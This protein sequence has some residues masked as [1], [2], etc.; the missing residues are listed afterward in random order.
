[1]SK[2]LIVDDE[3]SICWGVARVCEKLGHPTRSASSAEAGLREAASW[4]PD[5]IVLDVRLPGVDGIT[6]IES[7]RALLG[8]VP[9]VIVTAFGDMA[10]AV[11]AVQSDAFDYLLKPFGVQDIQAIIERALKRAP[12]S[13]EPPP[14]AGSDLIGASTV[15]Q[16]LYKRVALAAASDASVLLQGESGSGKELVARAIH[17]HS[18]RSK[19]RFVAVNVAAL[20]PSLAESELFGHVDG[21]FT[22]ATRTRPGLLAQADG[23]TLFLDEVAD[24]PLPLQVKLLRALEE[25]AVVPVGGDEPTPTKF[26]VVAATH[27]NLAQCVAAG[28]FRH[29]L[30]YRICA[31][32]VSIPPL[33]QRV[34]DIP[35]LAAH[36]MSLAGRSSV[37]LSEATLDELRSREW[38]G[39]VRELRNAIEHACVLSRSGVIYPEHLPPAQRRLDE[40][41]PATSELAV[42]AARRADELLDDPASEAVVYERLM[43]EIERPLFERALARYGNECAPAARALG[44]HRTTLKRKLDELESST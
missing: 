30:Y 43:A 6:A 24:I 22:G 23:G 36:F 32:E 11:R 1:M 37:R 10:T 25:G 44:L 3:E 4:R 27:Q 15:M 38:P 40:P 29:D 9:I 2:V 13:I 19:G 33:R 41:M 17:R 14:S 34:E 8:P 26:R 42:V 35:A 5:L 21:A 20:S 7:F 31:F 28:D 16:S 12:R 18:A 39:N